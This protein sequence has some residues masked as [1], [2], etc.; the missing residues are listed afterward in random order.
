MD[1]I[2]PQCGTTYELEEEQITT[3]SVRV[4]CSACE[5]VFRVY[6]PT[7]SQVVPALQNWIVRSTSGVISH[8]P[9]QATLQKMIVERKV[10]ADDE[11]S[12]DG[13]AWQLLGDVP[14]FRPFFGLIEQATASQQMLS[15]VTGSGAYPAAILTP[16][17]TAPSVAAVNPSG[18]SLPATASA[19][20]PVLLSG[21]MDPGSTLE[22]GMPLGIQFGQLTPEQQQQVAASVI[23]QSD[24][25]EVAMAAA[26][27]PEQA[28][29]VPQPVAVHAQPAVSQPAA[30]A[31][32]VVSQ[33]AVSQP[34]V[35][36][37][38]V[39]EPA[40]Q[41]APVVQPTVTQRT[42]DSV[43]AAIERAFESAPQPPT[44][45]SSEVAVRVSPPSS[46]SFDG[47][48][49]QEVK[50]RLGEEFD[51]AP[52]VDE[53]ANW[54][55]GSAADLN[56]VPVGMRGV[57]LKDA[58]PTGGMS[59][60]DDA[61][62]SRSNGQLGFESSGM[63][64]FSDFHTGEDYL[65]GDSQE[66]L[67]K[68]KRNPLTT[69]LLVLLVL[70]G[71]VGIAY[72]AMPEL[73]AKVSVS[74]GMAETTPAAL[75][76]INDAN[77]TSKRFTQASFKKAKAL[78]TEAETIHG[79]P[80]LSLL[81]ARMEL[82]MAQLEFWMLQVNL[83]DKQKA[84]W[85]QRIQAIDK[86]I[87][88]IPKDDKERDAKVKA[89]E[90]KKA[91]LQAKLDR[92]NKAYTKAFKE[93]QKHWSAA[94]NYRKAAHQKNAKHPK[95][96]LADLHLFSLSGDAQ[97]KFQPLYKKLFRATNDNVIQTHLFLLQAWVALHK[98]QYDQSL[99]RLRKVQAD[100]PKWLYASF[101]RVRALLEQKQYKAAESA[102]QALAS[103]HSAHP[104]YKAML[105]YAE[106]AAPPK[107]PALV[108]NRTTPPETRGKQPDARTKQPDARGKKA[109][110]PRRRASGGGSFRGL[111]RYADSL[112]RRERY[113][114]AMRIYRK[115]MKKKKTSR[116]YSG[117]GWCA[118]ETS[119]PAAAVSYFRT[120]M[121]MSRSNPDAY[122]GM[123]LALRRQKKN[124]EAKRV[125]KQFL[126]RFS[127]HRDAGEVRMILRSLN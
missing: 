95:V 53:G 52:D 39:A 127:R 91:P 96:Q 48:I 84:I 85:T 102:L 83:A 40:P 45:T 88:A 97:T 94:E 72:V 22:F 107:K 93:Y 23:A 42:A 92:Y 77:R 20:G 35:S 51:L 103:K 41:P 54:F 111:M 3:K 18:A 74:L 8:V 99:Q 49:P 82:E 68:P 67:I 101:L 80:F 78:L 31:Q 63:R 110:A 106:E 34:A 25:T 58:G 14:D 62:S 117:L 10:A 120:A 38:A 61:P 15:A 98:K 70:L 11:L 114:S 30:P 21:T 100:Q 47:P 43:P 55:T 59:F 37:P 76:K 33:P 19:V 89:E 90:A 24:K 125:L 66:F 123:G 73:V 108:L 119:G 4:K 122:F 60:D 32:P 29:A 113:K 50:D 7:P 87:A 81:A 16:K 71:G 79:G 36:Q 116:V 115:A 17:A 46:A 105:Q 124:S 26:P 86:A 75:Q 109:P 104:V 118:L 126:S 27:D 64:D 65:T 57:E 5:Y 13:R 1:V 28:P 56:E 6:K 44:S 112:R 9:D 12:R 69:V 121:R 2:C